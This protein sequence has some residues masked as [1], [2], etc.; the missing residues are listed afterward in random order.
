M[1]EIEDLIPNSIKFTSSSDDLQEQCYSFI[2]SLFQKG[3]SP[4]TIKEYARTISHFIVFLNNYLDH[5]VRLQDI[6]NLDKITINSYLSYYREPKKDHLSADLKKRFHHQRFF[7][8]SK[9]PVNTLGQDIIFFKKKETQELL[10]N[11]EKTFNGKVKNG[12]ELENSLKDQKNLMNKIERLRRNNCIKFY[13]KN[14]EK[15]ARSVARCTSVLRTFIDFLIKKNNWEGHNIKKIESSRFKQRTDNKVFEEDE[16]I[17]FL[18]YLDPD[19]NKI[20]LS[21]KQSNWERRRDLSILYFLYSSGLRVS[22]VL[23]FKK[24]NF[25]FKEFIKIKGKGNKERFIVVL[26]IVNEKIGKYL[27][28]YSHSNHELDLLDE[29]PLFIK[30]TKGVKRE[31]SARDIQRS[32]KKNI[33]R[34]D[35]S[36]PIFSTPHSLRHSF[37]SHILRGGADIRTIQELLGHSSLAS[38][39]IYTQ[40]NE[41]ALLDVYDKSHPHSKDKI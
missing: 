38:T 17:D 26:D 22:E 39:Q 1:R 9:I 14:K 20:N 5:S 28:S 37:A 25:P 30:L 12:Q 41:K 11:L 15:S 40:L 27:D 36:Y 8:L 33:Q 4:L 29:D 23:Q 3:R 34:F 7:F 16:I 6:K 19:I 24:K 18:Q 32:M 2:G 13:D 21:K 35:G 31:I 10:K